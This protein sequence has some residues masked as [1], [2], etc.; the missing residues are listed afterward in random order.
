MMLQTYN[1]NKM[2]QF[3]FQDSLA[4]EVMWCNQQ[5]SYSAEAIKFIS[6]TLWIDE[7]SYQVEA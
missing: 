7:R 5:E 4:Q 3:I 1:T 6:D 2:I